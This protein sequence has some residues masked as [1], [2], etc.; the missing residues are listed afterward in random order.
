MSKPDQE[1]PT[2]RF[3]RVC[4]SPYFA[5]AGTLLIIV[6][7]GMGSI[8]SDEVRNAFPFVGPPYNHLCIHAFVF[9][10]FALLA[11]AFFFFRQDAVDKEQ[12]RAQRETI[13][14]AKELSLLIRTLPPADFLGVFSLLYNKATKA[15][16]TIFGPPKSTADVAVFE[17]AVRTMLRF[18]AI[19]VQQFDGA[20]PKVRYAAN[21]MIFR[22]TA[23][24]TSAHR[25]ALRKRLKFSDEAVAID[26]LKGVLELMKNLSVVIDDSNVQPDNEVTDIVL[27]VPRTQVLEGKYLVLPGA[28]QAFVEKGPQTYPSTDQLASWCKHN[29]DFAQHIQQKVVE[30]Y[31]GAKLLRSFVS[32]PV[33]PNDDQG[34]DDKTKD[35]IAVVNIHCDRENILRVESGENGRDSVSQFYDV[36]RP[37][38]VLLTQVL[39]A[40][41]SSPYPRQPPGKPRSNKGRA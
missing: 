40:M 5:T 25:E 34:E 8:W 18:L 11:S 33:F 4:L 26:Q 24:M 14:R 1:Q 9:W 15:A 37:M 28:P 27:P 22:N 12:A 23:S 41:L 21:I 38:Q 32:I 10:F 16:E 6:A 36:I 7:G 17:Q 30:Y 3:K 39:L 29:G 2:G 13:E 20:D 19:L 31:Q 35:P